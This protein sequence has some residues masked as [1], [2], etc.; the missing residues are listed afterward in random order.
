MYSVYN[1]INIL[2]II[3]YN[4]NNR[5]VYI[6]IMCIKYFKWRI[7]MPLLNNKYRHYSII[8]RLP[9]TSV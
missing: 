7:N 9:T 3:Y 6:I 1:N 2:I 5:L 4:I 8:Y